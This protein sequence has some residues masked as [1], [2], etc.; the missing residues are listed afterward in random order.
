MS[1]SVSGGDGTT[2]AEDFDGSTDSNDDHRMPTVDYE[3]S[4]TSG[5]LF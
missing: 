4:K 2:T 3:K 1:R 5:I